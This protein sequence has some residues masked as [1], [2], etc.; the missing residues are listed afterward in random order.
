MA[1]QG[2]ERWD[3][4]IGSNLGEA[5]KFMSVSRSRDEIGRSFTELTDAF[6]LCRRLEET[7]ETAGYFGSR[8]K[9]NVSAAPGASFLLPL[10]CQ[11]A[12]RSNAG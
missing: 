1:E 11:G 6:F 12:A 5:S 7:A 2:L 4:V 8:P 3:A 10:G 9:L